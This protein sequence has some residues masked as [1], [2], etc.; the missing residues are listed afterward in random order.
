MSRAQVIICKCGAK[1]AACREPECYTDKEWL[2]DLSKYVK[3]G[4]SVDMIGIKEFEL[5]SCRC[6][7]IKKKKEP[8]LF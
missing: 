4:C 1:F 3:N 8:E 7:E 2:R 6:A 5:E